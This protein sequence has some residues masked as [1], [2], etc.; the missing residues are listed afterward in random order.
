VT[1]NFVT[2]ANFEEAW[3]VTARKRP[4]RARRWRK[5]IQRD[6]PEIAQRIHGFEYYYGSDSETT[7]TESSGWTSADN[8]ETT[9]TTA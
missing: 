7:S 3:R 4:R 9:D 1:Q 2:P 8:L 5:L 6:F